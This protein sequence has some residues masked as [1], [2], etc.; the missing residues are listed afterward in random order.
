MLHVRLKKFAARTL[1]L[2]SILFAG[3][4]LAEAQSTVSLSVMKDATLR[5]GSYA[6]TAHGGE[7]LLVTRAS[8]DPTYVRRAALTFDTESTVPDNAAIRSATLVLTVRGGNAATRQLNAYGMPISFEEPS[9][10]WNSRSSGVAWPTPGGDTTATYASASVTAAVGSQVSFDV[11]AHV[12]AVLN[13]QYGSRYSRFLVVDPGASSRDSYK[14]FHS[15]ESSAADTRPTLIVTY[16]AAGGATPPPAPGPDAAGDIILGPEHVTARAG[17][18]VV[19]SNSGAINGTVVRHPDAGLAKIETALATPANYFEMKFQAQAGKAYRLWIHGRAD[20]DYWGNDSVHVQFSGSVTSSGSATYRTGTTSAAWVNLEECS[21]C[22]LTGWQ[23]QDNGYGT[24]VLGPTIYFDTASTQTIRIQTREDGLSIDRILLS[25]VTY[26]SS[27]PGGIA[28]APPPPPD[29]GGDV[30]LGPEHVSNRAGR[31]TVESNS[32]AIN[33]TVIRHPDA[34]LAKIDTALAAPANYFELTFQAQAGTAYR[35]WIHGRAD[36]DYWG[37][38]S[39]HVQFSGSVT[40]TGSATYRIGTTSAAWVNLE[41]CSGCGLTGWQW[42]DNG[43]GR[44]VLGPKIYFAASGTQTMRVQ[45]REDGLAIDRILLS[46]ATYM[47]VPPPAPAPAPAPPPGGSGSATT[48]KVLDWNIH[49]GVGTDGVYD[50]ERIGAWMAKWRPDLISI[51]ETEKYTSFGN[52]NQPE[53]FK[54]MLQEATGQTWY[55]HFTQEWGSF[56][57]NGKGNLLLSRFPFTATGQEVLSYSRTVG[58]GT[59]VINGRNVTLMTTHLDPN[60]RDYR[61]TQT[62]ELL[63]I[64]SAWPEPRLVMGDLNA[65]PDQPSI[66]LMNVS[67]YD[68]FGEAEKLGTSKAPGDIDPYGATRNGRI[69]YIYHSKGSTT[70]LRLM[71]SEVPDTRDANGVMPSDHRPVLTTY[72]VR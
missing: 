16:E 36:S 55:Y 2:G 72:E 54:V 41:E 52:E 70:V 32:G 12:Q 68:S 20:R 37:N 18:W 28:P 58:I 21:G 35:L 17:R 29:A 62:Q 42:Q 64:A 61:Y 24:G 13:G 19:E 6:N 27:P 63:T 48:I 49:H 65:W 43:Y 59:V 71:S 14:E 33:G 4:T 56:N 53:R 25:P 39:V 23:W 60:S 51:N 67:N 26:M 34:G 1:A 30:V 7:A 57:S 15:R 46:P 11:S 47:S 69:D 3:A 10:T 50:I 45:T 31:W 8:D 44:G 22:G 9:V 5:A 40:S 66:G 38:D